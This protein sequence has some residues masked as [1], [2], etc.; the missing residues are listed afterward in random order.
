MAKTAKRRIHGGNFI[1]SGTY[2]CTYTNPPVP[3]VYDKFEY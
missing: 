2:G 3:L 1:G